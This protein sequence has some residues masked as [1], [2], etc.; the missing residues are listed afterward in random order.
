[1]KDPIQLPQ[2]S[3]SNPKIKRHSYKVGVG[4]A[5]GAPA[6]QKNVS[7]YSSFRFNERERTYGNL[8]RHL[9]LGHWGKLERLWGEGQ[10]LYVALALRT[11]K[12][13]LLKEDTYRS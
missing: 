5:G 1:M 4:A 7:L 11:S 12:H 8:G 6:L 13:R 9:A 2:T 3:S 10:Q